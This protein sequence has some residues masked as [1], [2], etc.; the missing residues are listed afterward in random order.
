MT[1]DWKYIYSAPDNRE[2]L[3][4]RLNDPKESKNLAITEDNQDRRQYMKQL[5]LGHLKEGGE[6]EG[7][8]GDD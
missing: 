2:S 3:F 7:L 6:T 8:V 5:L 1:E 4:A